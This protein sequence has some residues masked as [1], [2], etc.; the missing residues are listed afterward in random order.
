MPTL[1]P[2]TRWKK[3]QKN[4]KP[5]DVVLMRYEGNVKDD[6]RLAMVEEIHPDA[7]GLV[8][9]VTVKFK[10]KNKKEPKL[11]CKYGNLIKE[12]VA[13]QRLHFLVSTNER[14]EVGEDD[15]EDPVNLS[16]V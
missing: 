14:S 11:V 3:E 2:Y 9:T 12:K 8:R 1:L 7:K 4:L 16:E 5:G 10:R 15:L 6:Y 13:V